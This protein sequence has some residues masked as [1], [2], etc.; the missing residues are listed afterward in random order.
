MG[1]K[2]LREIDPEENS[3]IKKWR[4]QGVKA[5]NAADTQALLQLSRSYCKA[6]KCTE[7][8]FGKHQ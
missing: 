7:C 1:M 2:L 5:R 4:E 8:L 3:I 6:K